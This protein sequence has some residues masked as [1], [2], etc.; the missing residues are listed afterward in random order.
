[1]NEPGLEFVWVGDDAVDPLNS[2]TAGINTRR[3][4]AWTA[5]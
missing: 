3:T 1:V 4:S 5:R 2:V